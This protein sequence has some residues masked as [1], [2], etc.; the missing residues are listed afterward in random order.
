[1]KGIVCLQL[2][3]VA[4]QHAPEQLHL[5]VGIVRGNN[6][7]RKQRALDVVHGAVD[8]LPAGR[9]KY[10]VVAVHK[11]LVIPGDVSQHAVN[12]G[13]GQIVGGVGHGGV[14]L[15]LGRELP[16]L[17]PLVWNLNHLVVDEAVGGR[18]LVEKVHQV[19]RQGVAQ[20]DLGVRRDRG[21]KVNLVDVHQR[22]AFDCSFTNFKPLVACAE[23]VEP[24]GL[25]REVEGQQPPDKRLDLHLVE[26]LRVKPFDSSS[27]TILVMLRWKDLKSFS[28]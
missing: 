6:A 28:S 19:H 15:A 13:H 24:V 4:G 27:A 18:Y 9:D 5:V 26:H 11:Q 1:M 2:G 14:A 23:V 3:G 12:V 16:D 8:V 20:V 17:C 10:V 22:N 7:E 25:L 21:G